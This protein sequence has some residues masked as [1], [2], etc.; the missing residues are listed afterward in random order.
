MLNQNSSTLPSLNE[1][2]RLRFSHDVKPVQKPVYMSDQFNQR[3]GDKINGLVAYIQG[4]KTVQP[5]KSSVLPKI[6]VSHTY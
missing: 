3:D 6:R 4:V 5:A 1:S 2:D